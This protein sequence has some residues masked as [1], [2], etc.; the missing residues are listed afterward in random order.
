MNA[1]RLSLLGAGLGA[2]VM[3]LLDPSRGN[4]RRA[5]V[6]DKMIRVTR[7]TRD[8]AGA[9][10]RDM[11]N[12]AQGAQARV[13]GLLSRQPADDHVMVERVRAA[14]GRIATHPRAIGVDVRNGCVTLT[15]DV[16]ASEAASIM[17]SVAGVRGVS[18][19]ENHMTT[20]ASAEG[21]P[22]LQ[23]ESERPGKWRTWMR[24]G[25]SPTAMVAGGA[26]L[27]AAV[28]S[29]SKMRSR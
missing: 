8:A 24:S 1:M 26:A 28:G 7:K 15:G 10:G 11:R 16:L 13:R 3:Y 5:L 19:V 18:D 23:G 29:A 20:H 17:N 6:R 2:G 22:S 12:R 9:T 21:I 4:R 27:A 14:L 25:W